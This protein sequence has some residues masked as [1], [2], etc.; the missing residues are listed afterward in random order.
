MNE[1]KINIIGLSGSGISSF[2]IMITDML[3]EK[4]FN[5]NLNGYN[6]TEEEMRKYIDPNLKQI[7]SALIEKIKVINIQ[8]VQASRD[9]NLK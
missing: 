9:L 5:I 7:Q 4:G 8:E 3:R 2:A 6:E 1:I